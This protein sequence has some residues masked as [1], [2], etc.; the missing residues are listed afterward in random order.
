MEGRHFDDYPDV[1]TPD[2]AMEVLCVG[3]NTIYNLLKDGTIPSRCLGKLYRISK[4]CL[5]D[6]MDSCYS[7][8]NIEGL[9]C[10]ALKEVC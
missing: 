9:S 8:D 4:K 5:Q 10:N 3:R 6:F 7:D 1:L 2:E